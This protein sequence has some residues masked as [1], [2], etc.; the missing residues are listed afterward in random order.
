MEPD[1]TEELT[2]LRREVQLLRQRVADLQ[3]RAARSG[4]P[5]STHDQREAAVNVSTREA[6]LVE[7]ERIVHVGSW[8]WDVGAGDVFWSDELYRIL[9]YDPEREPATTE[10]FFERVHPEDR[11]R[12]R[13]AS[14]AGANTGVAEQVEYRIA[15]PDGQLRYV[16]MTGTMLFDAGGK[17]RRIVGTVRDLSE[18]RALQ[19]QMQLSLELLEEAQ[20]IAQIGSWTFDIASRRTEW[21]AGMYRL[22][23]VDRATPATEELFFSLLMPED[24]ERVR[25]AHA[26][27]LQ[28]DWTE[29][30]ECRFVR[31]GGV[32]WQARV[33]TVAARDLQ[34]QLSAYRGTVHDITE[35]TRLAQRLTQVG[36]TEAVTRLAGGIAH[37]FNNLLTVI[38]A[39]LEL[40]AETAGMQAEI[41]DARRAVQS[42]RSLTDRL[43][44]LGRRAPLAKR[45][46]DANEL[47][48]RTVDLLRRVIGD[49]VRLVLALGSRLPP[50]QVDPALIEQALINLVINARDAMPHGGTVTLATRAVNGP[51]AACWVELEVGD[52]GPGMDTELKS[53]IFEPFF[54]TKGERGTGLGLPTVLA[55]VE[56]HGGTMEVESERGKGARFRMRLPAD[57]A[58]RPQSLAP[59]A[60]RAESGGA[61]REIL[62]VEDEPLVAAVIARSLERN[63]H[64]PLLAHRPSEALRLWEAHPDVAL[65]ICDVSM[66][67]MQG[68]ELVALLR[69]SGRAV[70]VIYVTGYQPHGLG[71]AGADTS[72][73][74]VLT[75]PFS[76]R[77][78]LRAVS[79]SLRGAG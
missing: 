78:L 56:Q 37:D 11:E 31:P 24:R 52:D 28:G 42:A 36:K 18:E 34:G 38:G 64:R 59:E 3:R 61:S 9:G 77:E 66:A 58:G 23:G 17:P 70:N 68:P 5:G 73:D 48:T 63:G 15:L 2:S 46:I 22:M 33:R 32:A 21:S 72:R 75:K 54:T 19:R 45:V 74:R 55:T 44:A 40:W 16:T 13:R 60:S 7:A 35:Q 29:E 76:P 1:A 25:A 10:R 49:R 71:E 39:N 8:V 12:V 47:V 53:R 62:V 43:L 65:V 50:V 6:L 79:E 26:R 57:S 67:E 69:Q 27:G 41:V 4:E 20:S 14:A 30:L 51:G